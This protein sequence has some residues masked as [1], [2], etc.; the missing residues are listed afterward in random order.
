MDA[1]AIESYSD[2]RGDAIEL[3][4]AKIKHLS[5]RGNLKVL[6]TGATGFL[7]SHLL[8]DFL[9]QGFSVILVKRRTSNLNRISQQMHRVETWNSDEDLNLLFSRRSD[10]DVIVHAATDYGRVMEAPTAAFWSNVAF[11]MGLLDLS[12]K[13]LVPLFVNIDT[14]FNTGDS[15]YDHLAAYT[16]S[17][18]HFQRW[19]R[20]CAE[21]GHTGFVNLRL[22][23]LYG[24]GDGLDKFFSNIAKRCLADE[25]IDLTAGEQQRDFIYIDD[26]IAGIRRI[27]EMESGRKIMGYR[28]YDVG[29]GIS[30]R[31]R[32]IV[33]MI[34]QACGGKSRLNFGAL[35]YRKGEF[36]RSCANSE[37]LRRLGWEPK[38]DI[39]SGIQAVVNDV[40]MRTMV[41]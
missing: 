34:C 23:H 28:E 33:E 41:S 4:G 26:A 15:R 35:P 24:P 16:M 5:G 20:Y 40:R 25:E 17:K 11:P 27:L 18:S 12:M 32:E 13:H 6:L 21:S 7:G 2:W 3:R 36:I 1:S 39:H 29:T 8:A 30:F 22:F 14:F 10:I 37:P 38:V 9:Q 31:I 19:G